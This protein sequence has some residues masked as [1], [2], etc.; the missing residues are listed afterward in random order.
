MLARELAHFGDEALGKRHLAPR[1]TRRLEDDGGHVVARLERGG[2]AACVVGR[3]Q[4]GLLDE[5]GRN[6]RRHAA[7]EVRHG[8]GSDAV[9]P[10]VEVADEADDLRLGR[11]G[12]GEPQRQMRGLGARRSEAHALGAGDQTVHQLG[13][14]HLQLVRGAPMRAEL[15]L[16]L[17]RLHHG[18]MAMAEQQRAVAAEV[19]DVFVAVDVP[20]AGARC[21]GGVDRIGHERT[22]VVRQAGGDHLAGARVKLGRAP[23]AAPIL[24][25]DPRVGSR[26][27]HACPLHGCRRPIRAHDRHGRRSVQMPRAGVHVRG[28]ARELC[29]IL[30]HDLS[31]LVKPASFR[32]CRPRR[33]AGK[34]AIPNAPRCSPPREMGLC[35]SKRG[36]MPCPT[37]LP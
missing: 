1:G 29:A 5:I 20:L 16:A 6:A 30:R 2:D 31:G 4:D 32:R 34:G 36:R 22:A 24:G 19:V 3:Q 15:H 18:R 9:V 8:A 11:K 21:S 17:D 7:L 27:R 12:A 13:P 25:L 33:A 14:S 26:L 10:A 28:W 23:R 37:A 35:R